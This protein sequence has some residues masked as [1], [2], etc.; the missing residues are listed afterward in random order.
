MKK[1]FHRYGECSFD[2]PAKL[3]LHNYRNWS[4]KS[5][6]KIQKLFK[7]FFSSKCSNGEVESSLKSTLTFHR[8]LAEFFPPDF[9][10]KVTNYNFCRGKNCSPESFFW[11]WESSFHK[12]AEIFL[13][14]P[15]ETCGQG[16][17]K[18]RRITY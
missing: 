4:E 7:I 5:P 11:K 14:K 13:T 10:T 2:R 12:D 16:P 6:Q 17:K 1:R 3:F 18:I 9:Q 8:Q 15:R